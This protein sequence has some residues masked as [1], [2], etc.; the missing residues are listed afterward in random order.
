MTESL[1]ATL[2]LRP[3]EPADR[4]VCERLWQ[5]F[6]HDLSGLT[7][8]LPFPDGT[9]RTERIE[10]AFT[11][12]DW[13]AYLFGSGGHPVG[14]GIVRGLGAPTRVLNSFFVVH[15][16]RRT[17]LGLRAAVELM[18][19]YPGPWE[20]AFQAA[21]PPA[22]AFW[23]RVAAEVAGEDWTEQARDVPGRPDLPPDLWITLDAAA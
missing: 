17:G 11:D 1:A 22:V 14:F 23:R 4:P 15:G 13:T 20:V 6:R 5:L 9:F 12:P 21:N 3:A 7:G 10:A 18:H 16:A 19:R 8:T 2:T